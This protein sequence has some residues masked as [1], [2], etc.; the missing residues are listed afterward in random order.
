MTLNIGDGRNWHCVNSEWHDTADGGIEGARTGDGD[1]LQGYCLAF[2]KDAAY[3]DLEATF[4]AQLL[5]DHA[6]IGFIVRAQ[7]PTHY[8]LLHFPQGG[9][10]YRAQHFW[11][12]LSIADGSGYL[13]M[14]R[15]E[16]VRRVASN[17]FGI[18]HQ[19]RVRVTGD[20]FQVWLNGHP[21]LNVRDSTY[22]AGRCGLAGFNAFSH[23]RVT[24][25]GAEVP[26]PAWDE[27]IPQV[28]NWFTPFPDSGTQQRKISAAKAPN[29]DILCAFNGDGNRQLGRSTDGGRTWT[30]GP[31]PQDMIGDLMRLR[32]GR[33]ICVA[34]QHGKGHWAE[35]PD[36]G[37]TWIN[38]TP[39]EPAVPWPDDP[40]RIPTTYQIELHDGTLLRFGPGAHSSSQEPIT[41]WGAVH[42]QG[43]ATR[44]TDSGKTWSFPV[45]LDATGNE[46]MGNLDLTEPATF[47]TRDG[48]LMCLIRPIYSPW[49]WETWSHDG[50][51]TWE[52]CVRGPFPGYAPSTPLR[53]ASGVVVL[54]VRFPGMT[55]HLTRDDGMTWDDGGG[56]T[57]MDTALWAMGSMVEVEP[58][59]VLFMHM[60]SWHDRMRARFFRVTETGLV[61]EWRH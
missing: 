30:V 20:R 23:G 22:Q 1:G 47:E 38:A 18:P 17:P 60:D 26:A 21:A 33:L 48:R 51:K 7:D 15:L 42:L 39:I 27:N 28:K 11:A 32:D 13:R 53:T 58:D 49:M 41:R 36:S 25:T 34:L 31:A 46:H 29:G 44:S 55:I 16:L 2:N 14:L 8:Y 3:T 4:T 45:N 50:G 59:V 5:T 19:A 61:P 57:F 56:G 35:S 10:S 37:Y 54:P 12:A 6:D 43:F 24:V 52:P 40:N 9:Q